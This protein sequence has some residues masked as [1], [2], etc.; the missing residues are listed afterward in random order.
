MVQIY[1]VNLSCAGYLYDAL[2]EKASPSRCSRV[3]R[4]RSREDAL[5]FLAAEALL[6]YAAWEQA[7]V[8][9]FSVETGSYGKPR[10]QGREDLHFNISHS[11][12]WVALAWSGSEVGIDVESVEKDR[13]TAGIASRFF[14]EEEQRFLFREET[15]QD[16]RFL[17]IWT[18]KESYL[19][20]LGTGLQKNLT[21][22][23]VRSMNQPRFYTRW[24]DSVCMTVCTQEDG[25]RLTFLQPEQLVGNK[26]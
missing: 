4:C 15:G 20:Y 22:F 13:N 11:G 19:K 9:D 6:R 10:I 7:G 14:T 16:R 1:T 24:L 23:C 21:S 18:A 26:G 17:E 12:D 2:Y 5:R 25:Y 3:D 8:T